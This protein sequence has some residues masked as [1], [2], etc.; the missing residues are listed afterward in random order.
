MNLTQTIHAKTT[1]SMTD[2]RRNPSK[3]MEI[4]GDLP[5]AVLN[6]NKPEAYLLSAKAYEALL[7]LVDDAA[8]IKTIQSRKGGKTVKVKLA[9]L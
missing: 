8:L 7:E 5:V 2:L 4:A 3:I 1:V 6:H 9:D